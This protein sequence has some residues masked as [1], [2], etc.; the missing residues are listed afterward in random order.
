VPRWVWPALAVATILIETA[1]GIVVN[2]L[3]VVPSWISWLFIPLV[4]ILVGLVATK[5]FRD[6]GGEG[7]GADPPPRGRGGPVASILVG[8][9]LLA[10]LAAQGLLGLAFIRNENPYGT[11]SFDVK[12]A[13]VQNPYPSMTNEQQLRF[14]PVRVNGGRVPVTGPYTLEGQILG[15]LQDRQQLALV[16][17]V[18]HST[19]DTFG[20]PGTGGYFFF[21]ESSQFAGNEGHWKLTEN[22][23]YP[24]SV[25]ITR[26]FTIVR[27]SRE[28]LAAMATSRADWAAAGNKPEQYPGMKKLPPDTTPLATFEVSGGLYKGQRGVCKPK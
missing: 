3:D 15:P 18:D 20:N 17:L 6:V 27:G 21:P 8:A 1:L 11:C 22:L 2:H 25:T 10:V 19:C 23:G 4:I 13:G 28:A 9:V 12:A 7:A 14:C 16:S 24:E 5:E 26:T